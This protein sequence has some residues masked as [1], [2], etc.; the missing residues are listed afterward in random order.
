MR[1]LAP[2]SQIL[3]I[4]IRALI[5]T[6]NGL[7]LEA[8]TFI[9]ANAL[10]NFATSQHLLKTIYDPLLLALKWRNAPQHPIHSMSTSH[11]IAR[12]EHPLNAFVLP[13][14]GTVCM[15]FAVCET[16]NPSN[17]AKFTGVLAAD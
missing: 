9:A 1:S 7:I 15:D 13:T 12:S 11:Y 5:R 16:Y 8:K 10:R 3:T 2:S 6:S 14:P 17:G 4:Q